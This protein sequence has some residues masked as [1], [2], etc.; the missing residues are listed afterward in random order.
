MSIF[1]NGGFEEII[2]AAAGDLTPEF[3]GICRLLRRI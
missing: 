1:E 3:R 2:G